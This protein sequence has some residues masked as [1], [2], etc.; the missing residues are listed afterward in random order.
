CLLR[1]NMNPASNAG[2]SSPLGSTVCDEGVNFSVY[3]R[4]ASGVELLLFDKEDDAKPARIIRIDPA[5]NRT[6]HYW[7]VFVRGVQPGQIYG[8][9]AQGPNDPANGMRFDSAKVLLDPY[10]RG[11]A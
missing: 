4:S 3:S 9:R 2:D 7:H 1:F 5:L 11:V 8:Y 6:Y 10:A